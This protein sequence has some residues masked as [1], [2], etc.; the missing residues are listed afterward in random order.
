M[1]K[2]V[3]GLIERNDVQEL[4]A[5]FDNMPSGEPLDLQEEKILL[6]CFSEVAVKTYIKRF[7]FSEKAEILF[8]AKAPQDILRE[9]INY[10]GLYATTQKFV[11]DRNL[12]S[13]AKEFTKMR[14]F[15]NVDYLL[16]K[17]QAQIIRYAFE[18]RGFDGDEQVIKLLRHSNSTLINDYIRKGYFLSEDVQK[19]IIN[20]KKHFNVFKTIVFCNYRLFKKKCK[21]MSYQE[22]MENKLEVALSEELQLEVLETYDR[23][24]IEQMLITTPLAPA[25]QEELFNKNYDAEW[26][27]LHVSHL[28]G[29]GG[30]R[31][32]P[33][34]EEKLFK[35]L[36]KKNLD[37]CLTAFRMQ[38]DVVFIR[39][40]SNK[41]VLK[42]I[43]EHWLTDEG[44]VE[45][46]SRG[47]GELISAF[48]SR[49]T[50]EHGLCWQA[51]VKLVEVCSV[52]LINKYTSFH[53]MCGEALALLGQKSADALSFY[54]T[55]HAY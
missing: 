17:G 32:E 43:K 55:K 39:L 13:V 4:K 31:F 6:E 42:Y 34:T 20:E 46:I 15:D 49:Y 47:N 28:Y 38:D 33:E 26:F 29:T 27:R 24:M 10:H 22:M 7:R 30:Y 23:M 2:K 14:Y 52:D 5:Y 19:L 51:E 41:A 8:V 21:T 9:Y 44:Q 37:D 54:Y 18:Y 45:L 11:I 16:D 53:T 25:V 3:I 40:A 36:A 1:S 12:E 50:S 48:L 35:V